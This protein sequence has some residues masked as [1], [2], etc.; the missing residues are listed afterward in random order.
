MLFTSD[1]I[2]AP[3]KVDLERIPEEKEETGEHGE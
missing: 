3:L 1:E 2:K